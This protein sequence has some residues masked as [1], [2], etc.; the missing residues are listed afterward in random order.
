MEPKKLLKMDLYMNKFK[1]I[2]D[3]PNYKINSIGQVRNIKTGK[4][5]NIRVSK[6]GYKTCNLWKN[7]KYKTKYIH[8]LIATY[9]IKNPYGYN[10]INHKNGN[11]LDNSIN[12]L[13][14]CSIKQNVCHAIELG[15]IPLGEKR[16]NSKLTNAIAK[17]IYEELHNNN[18]T[19]KELSIKYKISQTQ[20]SDIRNKKAWKQIHKN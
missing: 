7:N 18:C 16:K 3:F 5:I 14:W 6:I 13:E 9:F 4:F 19:N 10:V 12:N 15:L 1:T 20:I 11:K 2:K 8:R 17:Q